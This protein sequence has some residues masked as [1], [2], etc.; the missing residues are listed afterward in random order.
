MLSDIVALFLA[1]L[2]IVFLL[3]SVI[4][5]LLIWRENEAV[6]LSIPLKSDDKGIYDRIINLRE[7]CSFLRIQKQCTIAVINYGASDLFI[8][9]LKKQFSEYEF[10]KIINAEAL[11]KEL[12]T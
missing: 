12:H 8:N 5:K 1:I 10:I 2:G 3:F 11:I 9:R 4:F 6:V 7:I